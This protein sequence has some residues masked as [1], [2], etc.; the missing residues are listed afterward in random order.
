MRGVIARPVD[1]GRTWHDGG[2]HISTQFALEM[3]AALRVRDAFSVMVGGQN[4][5]DAGAIANEANAQARVET[6]PIGF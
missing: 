4:A 3:V 1:G 5:A 2:K 6:A